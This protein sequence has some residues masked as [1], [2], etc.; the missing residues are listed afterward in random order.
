MAVK[1]INILFYLIS[2]NLSQAKYTISGIPSDK[3]SSSYSLW[4]AGAGRRGKAN[5]AET[6][7]LITDEPNNPGQQY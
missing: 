7:I 1:S 5:K 6:K 4:K 2:S 3:K